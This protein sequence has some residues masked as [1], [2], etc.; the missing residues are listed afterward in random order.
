MSADSGRDSPTAPLTYG[1]SLFKKR[2]DKSVKRGAIQ[3]AALVLS[4]VPAFDT[5]EPIARA[6][7]NVILVCRFPLLVSLWTG[8]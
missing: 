8:I 7:V 5:L 2:V 3:R 6:L 4:S 1:I